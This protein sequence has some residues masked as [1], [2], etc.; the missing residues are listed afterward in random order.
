MPLNALARATPH[1]LL[2]DLDHFLGPVCVQSEPGEQ[3]SVVYGFSD[4]AAYD[5]F[6]GRSPLALMP[7]PLVTLHLRKKAGTAD[8]SVTL[9]VLD[10][11][12]PE[13]P[14][15]DATTM[16]SVLTAHLNDANEVATTHHLTFD[17]AAAAYRVD[18]DSG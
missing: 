5:T 13:E 8:A 7:Y 4:K 3:L 16:E 14:S 15:L 10:A 17:Q 6:I 12:G 18:Q 2:K 9:L 1:Y 11:G